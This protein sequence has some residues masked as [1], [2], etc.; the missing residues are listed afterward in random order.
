MLLLLLLVNGWW[1]DFCE[2]KPVLDL[3]VSIDAILLV[4][5]S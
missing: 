5:D 4:P 1:E 2:Y 3:E